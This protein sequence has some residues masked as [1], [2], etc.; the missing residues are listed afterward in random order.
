[1]FLLFFYAKIRFLNLALS[2]GWFSNDFMI[3]QKWLTILVVGP[4]CIFCNETRA[5]R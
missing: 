3:I 4:S 5:K 1:M 2:L